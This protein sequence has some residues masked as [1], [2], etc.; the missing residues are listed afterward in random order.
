MKKSTKVE[1]SPL[2]L[3]SDGVII[4]DDVLKLFGGKVDPSK[5]K[6][7][8]RSNRPNQ[9]AAAD[10]FNRVTETMNYDYLKE[11]EELKNPKPVAPPP[12]EPEVS[13]RLFIYDE[14]EGKVKALP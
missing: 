8:V 7:G 11:Q 2:S 3:D 6:I 10:P 4:T 14:E 5:I 12:P 9:Q 13:K 1:A